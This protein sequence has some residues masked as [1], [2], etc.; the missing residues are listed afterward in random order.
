VDEN[1][2]PYAER[3]NAMH[4]ALVH[5]FRTRITARLPLEEEALI[6]DVGCGDGFFT[7]LL[8]ELVPRGQAVGLDMSPAFLEAAGKRLARN[9]STG[10]VRLVEGDANKFPFQESSVDAIWSGH[11]MQSYEK[12]PHVLSEFRRVLRPGGFL[13]ILETDNIHSI[14]L[15]WPPDLELAVRQAEHREIGTE[16]SYIGTYFPRFAARLV[17]E[18]GFEDFTREYIFI[19]RQKACEA[20][21][22]YIEL[23]LQNLFEQIGERLTSTNRQRLQEL[24]NRE[25]SGFLP[26]Q[27]NFFF[28]SLQVLMTARA[29][30]VR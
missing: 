20:L 18:A 26:R 21:T 25:S 17:R 2:P 11:S 29:G 27:E 3:L 24:S 28:G 15:S 5:D 9:F 7:G 22:R 6:V 30:K 23:Y 16:D 1:L 13:A 14:M 12:I 10:G 8:A 19:S 4:R